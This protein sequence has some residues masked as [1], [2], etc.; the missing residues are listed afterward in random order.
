MSDLNVCYSYRS[1]QCH[2]GA[3][4]VIDMP[5]PS[6]KSSDSAVA[7]AVELHKFKIHKAYAYFTDSMLHNVCVGAVRRE[8]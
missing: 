6:S 7:I 8:K 1:I 5:P 2:G 3:V 4:V